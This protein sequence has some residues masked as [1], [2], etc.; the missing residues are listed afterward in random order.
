[1]THVTP[2]TRQDLATSPTGDPRP[3]RGILGWHEPFPPPAHD[4][5]LLSALR[6]G[7]EMRR[8]SRRLQ[9]FLAEYEGYVRDVLQ[10]SQ[11]EIRH[12]L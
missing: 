3:V 12:I 1:M 10:P 6:P 11:D 7:L 4:E 8:D 2:A 5:Q 9:R